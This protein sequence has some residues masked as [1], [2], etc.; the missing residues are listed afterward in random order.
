MVKNLP[1][2]PKEETPVLIPRS[3]KSSGKGN[4]NLTL[5]FLPGKSHRGV[6]WAIVHGVAK[7][8]T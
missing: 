1:A 6:W 2:N 5:L 3:G 7:S 8:R 4:G